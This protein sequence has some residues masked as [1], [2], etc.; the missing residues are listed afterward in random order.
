MLNQRGF[1]LAEV[2]V[3][4]AIITVGFAGIVGMQA[5]SAYSVREGRYRSMAVA[6][7]DERAEQAWAARWDG[8][9]DCLGLSPSPALPPVTARC[10]GT[11]AGHGLFPDES[12]G[13]LPPPFEQLGRT[14]RVQTCA[15]AGTCAIA[16]ADLRLVSVTVVY[17]PTSGL[18]G[19]VTGAEQSM[20]VHRL[21]GRRR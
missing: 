20:V 15:T 21:V 16:T 3:A 2:L 11:G 8:T 18:G 13:T 7:V 17:S 10:S 19:N 5:L 9:D 4:A 6:L 1:S 12:P 14:V